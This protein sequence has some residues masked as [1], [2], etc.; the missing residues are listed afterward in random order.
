MAAWLRALLAVATFCAAWLIV[1]PARAATPA[2]PICDPRGAIGF[3]P[4]IQIQDAELSL[5]IP[6]DCFEVTFDV[7]E[8]ENAV[9]GGGGLLAFSFS[10]EPLV[11]QSVSVPARVSS[12]RLSVPVG[13]LVRLPS[14]VRF[15]L[16]R[17]PRA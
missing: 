16:E 11:T 7:A 4:P 6:A 15:S 13:A 1:L 5:D 8:T 3:A 10:Q 17:P 14:G 2:A 9:P 12:E